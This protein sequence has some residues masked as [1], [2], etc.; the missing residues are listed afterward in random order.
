MSKCIQP[1]GSVACAPG[2]SSIPSVGWRHLWPWLR[3]RYQRLRVEGD[4]MLPTLCSGTEILIQP[5]HAL[6]YAIG[7][8]V[9]CQRPDQ[10]EQVV[11][12][13]IDSIV[14]TDRTVTVRGDN[15][16]ASTDSR[17]FGAVAMSAILGRVVCRLP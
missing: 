16:D 1:G 17:D 13:R 14:A 5:N 15:P 2:C 12:K 6:D 8:V 3:G 7:D 10:S 4:S 11:I 9:C